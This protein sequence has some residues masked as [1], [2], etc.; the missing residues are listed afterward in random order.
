MSCVYA[1]LF[2]VRIFS[3]LFWLLC[4]LVLQLPLEILRWAGVLSPVGG[5]RS[6]DTFKSVLITG[7]SVGIGA[8]LARAFARPGVKLYLTAYSKPSLDSIKAECTKLGADVVARYIDVR[9]KEEM[10]Q[11]VS[12]AHEERPL[13]LVIANAGIVPNRNGLDEMHKVVETNLLGT[14]NTVVPAVKLLQESGRGGHI[15]ML[16]STGGY[17]TAFNKYMLG[18]TVS[19]HGI[20]VYADGLRH[21]LHPEG[22]KVSVVV[23]GFVES[24]MVVK[25]AKQGVKFFGLVSNKDACE[26]IVKGIEMN[27]REIAFP[28]LLYLVVRLTQTI[29]LFFKELMMCFP[30]LLSA[31]PYKTMDDIIKKPMTHGLNEDS[32]REYQEKEKAQ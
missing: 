24:R 12:K 28:A 32:I 26:R 2:V 21:I 22:I 11:F 3:D 6:R 7:G 9:N 25:Q 31:D 23:P 19:K 13:D 17:V 29:P 5:F 18:Y 30:I 1:A 10:E 20:R 27:E 16:S 14:L 15:V 4:Y 8:G